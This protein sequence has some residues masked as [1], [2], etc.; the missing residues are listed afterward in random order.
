MSAIPRLT[1]YL[2]VPDAAGAI[3]FYKKAMGA[4]QEGEAHIMPNT[5]KIMHARLLING[6]LIML[7]DDFS[8]SMGGPCMTAL[9]LGGSPV[10][11][12]LDVDDAKAFWE[13]AVAGGVTVTM[14]L[15][16]MFWGAR[17][18]QFTDPYGHRWSVSQEL[19]QMSDEEMKEAAESTL[20][21]KGT[22]M[23]DAA[24]A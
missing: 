2:T 8:D 23:G 10:V 19:K 9:K 16:D 6:S 18:G 13:T 5:S 1:P 15:A 12:A 11:L 14:P 7:A 17:Y 4:T 20:Q 21:E 22:L 24:A 3:E